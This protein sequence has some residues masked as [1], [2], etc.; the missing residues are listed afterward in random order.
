MLRAVPPPTTAWM[1]EADHHLRGGDARAA[2][3]GVPEAGTR[4]EGGHQVV[5]DVD[6]VRGPGDGKRIGDASPHA[7]ASA[8]QFRPRRV[9]AARTGQRTR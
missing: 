3:V 1:G 9:A 5:G 4:S 2:T 6:T 8:A 7:A